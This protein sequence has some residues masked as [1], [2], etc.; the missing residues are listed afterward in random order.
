MSVPVNRQICVSLS[1]RVSDF[2]TSTTAG[3]EGASSSSSSSSSAKGKMQVSHCQ[4]LLSGAG[5]LS[6]SSFF[7]YCL[8]AMDIHTYIFIYHKEAN[9]IQA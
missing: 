9:S 2:T 7:F 1:L 6:S 3:N 8:E 5:C 4:W